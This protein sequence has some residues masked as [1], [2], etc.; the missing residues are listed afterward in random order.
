MNSAKINFTYKKIYPRN[1]TAYMWSAIQ[2]N[3]NKIIRFFPIAFVPRFNAFKKWGDCHI[4]LK[5]IAHFFLAKY[6]HVLKD[7]SIMA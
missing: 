1:F 5:G 2:I 7:P 3:F 6:C 4:A